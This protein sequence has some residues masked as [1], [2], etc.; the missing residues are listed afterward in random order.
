MASFMQKMYLK[1]SLRRRENFWGDFRRAKTI[2]KIERFCWR[3][4]ARKIYLKLL[5]FVGGI[6]CRNVSFWVWF[7]WKAGLT[8]WCTCQIA[9]ISVLGPGRTSGTSLSYSTCHG[10]YDL[11]PTYY[12][13]IRSALIRLCAKVLSI[14]NWHTDNFIGPHSATYQFFKSL[15][16]VSEYAWISKSTVQNYM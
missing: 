10:A 16:H 2:E 11:A 14:L 9:L 15:P 3:F 5:I 6:P 4:R 12:S 13:I 7:L 8:S 1:L